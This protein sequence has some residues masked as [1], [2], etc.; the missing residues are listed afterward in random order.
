M[1]NRN[2][3]AEKGGLEKGRISLNL[4]I[5]TT[6]N[7]TVGTLATKK[8]VLT[9]VRTGVGAYTVTME[10]KY[11][12]RL[13]IAAWLEGTAGSGTP[14]GTKAVTVNP[15]NVVVGSGVNSFKL[16]CLQSSGAAG[17]VDDAWS[18]VVSIEYKD[19]LV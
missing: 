12:G 3:V 5:P 10:D 13:A 6:T 7:G 4:V 15:Y 8:G 18:V 14:A 1:A 11:V 16:Q 17:E 9:V 19:S 2:W